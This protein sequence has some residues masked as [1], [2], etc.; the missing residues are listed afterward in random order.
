MKKQM[1]ALGCAAMLVTTVM[2][3]SGCFNIPKAILERAGDVTTKAMNKH[4]V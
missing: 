1:R 3:F 2:A 4:E